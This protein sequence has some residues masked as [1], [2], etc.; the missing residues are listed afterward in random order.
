[1]PSGGEQLTNAAGQ[2]GVRKSRVGT[3][4]IKKKRGGASVRS[5]IMENWRAISLVKYPIYAMC[6]LLNIGHDGEE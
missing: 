3:G 6:A 5:H 2:T 4:P 1:M